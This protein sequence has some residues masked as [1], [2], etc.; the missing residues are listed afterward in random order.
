MCEEAVAHLASCCPQFDAGRLRCEYGNPGC[1]DVKLAPVFS[2]DDSE[3]ITRTSCD[4][5]VQSGVCARAQ[6][7][8]TGLVECKDD[9]EGCETSSPRVCQ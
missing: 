8:T 6:Q 7:A 9:A 4:A 1:D 3:C 2:Q 5:L